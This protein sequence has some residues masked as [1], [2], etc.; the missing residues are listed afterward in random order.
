[1]EAA[2]LRAPWL[3]T[4]RPDYWLLAG[5]ALGAVALLLT[6]I[7][8]VE[9]DMVFGFADTASHVVIPRRVFD[10]GEPGL[11]QLGTHWGPLF[12]VLQL[13]LVWIWPLYESGAS[14]IAVSMVASLV[15]VFYL[16]QLVLLVDAG[17]PAA[18]VAAL[19]LIGSPSFLYAGVIPML[20]ATIMAVSTA[21]IFYLTQWAITG[22]G[23]SLVLAGLTLTAAMLAHFDTWALGPFEFAI[24]LAVAH[25][26]WRSNKHTEATALLWLLAGSY[27]ALLFFLMNLMI[28]GNPFAFTQGFE[29]TG[30]VFSV[31]HHGLGALLDYPHAAV[32]TAGPGLLGAGVLGVS[33]FAWRWRGDPRHLVPLLLFYPLAWYSLQAI[34]T[35]SIIVPGHELGDWRNL[36]YAIT[37]LPAA[38]FF[39]AV[40][41]RKPLVLVSITLA[42]LAFAAQ[43]VY[44][45][46]VAAWED[47][48]YDFPESPEIARAARWLGERADGTRVLIPFHDSSVDR[49]ELLSDL[50]T[51][52]FIDANDTHALRLA[53]RAA[54]T[55]PMSLRR[56]Q[57]RW[58]VWI[59]NHHRVEIQ[60]MLR[61]SGGQL[62]HREESIPGLDF[63]IRIYS[64]LRRCSARDRA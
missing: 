40:G 4:G 3:K 1:V 64:L 47:A 27:G 58:L 43:S 5:L 26:R 36:R 24:V 19:L 20:P 38:A 32:L 8:T 51:R 56:S 37:L 54:A 57:V 46:R 60:R 55:A 50:Q 48:R 6:A 7:V 10:N 12:H 13:P 16:Y 62:C 61:T 59:G 33:F 35:G 45:G 34:T 17:K 31:S 30:D 2:S 63:S 44:D 14:G 29:G 49:F 39:V 21:N 22:R 53:R 9:R 18:F 11:A 41:F 15:T 28:F 23:L 25:S 42:V 52:V